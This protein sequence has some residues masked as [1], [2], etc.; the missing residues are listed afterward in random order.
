MTGTVLVTGASRGIG[1]EAARA[2]A[3]DGA[4]VIAHYGSHREGAAEAEKIKSQANLQKEELLAKARGDAIRIE[5][6]AYAEAS[7]FFEILERNPPLAM[8]LLQLRA[9]EASLKDRTTLILD[10]NSPL[11]S[12]LTTQ[13]T[14]GTNSSG[15]TNAPADTARK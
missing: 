5:G 8:F 6:Q 13:S 14:G 11:V 9:T 12:L 2:L 1:A 3:T 4:D 7:K 10:P 15:Q